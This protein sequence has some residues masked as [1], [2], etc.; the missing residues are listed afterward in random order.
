MV[1]MD[2]HRFNTHIIDF[3]SSGADASEHKACGAQL[4]WLWPA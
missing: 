3:D 2:S 1:T 4:P